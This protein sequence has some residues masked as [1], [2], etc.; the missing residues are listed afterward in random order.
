MIQEAVERIRYME[1]CFDTVQEN[2]EANPELI[3]ILSDYQESGQWR[4]DYELDEQGLLP[5]DLK[6]GVLSQDALYDFLID[7]PVFF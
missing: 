7:N 4:R 3:K 6:R 5:R 1:K 2:P